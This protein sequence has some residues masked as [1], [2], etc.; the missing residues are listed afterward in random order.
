MVGPMGS[1]NSVDLDDDG[2]GA[3]EVLCTLGLRLLELSEH[4]GSTYS[5]SSD[6]TFAGMASLEGLSSVLDEK[7]KDESAACT[8]RHA[9]LSERRGER[10]K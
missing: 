7:R 6:A 1:T 9:G 2:S 5:S 4:E 10:S 3:L 8:S